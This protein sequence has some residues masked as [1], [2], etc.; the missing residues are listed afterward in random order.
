MILLI[1][2]DRPVRR[3]RAVEH[4]HG[5]DGEPVEGSIPPA[6]E[7][8]ARRVHEQALHH[9]EGIGEMLFSQDYA[10][11]YCGISMEEP[12]PRNFSFN[13]PHGACTVCTGLGLRMEV[14]ADAVVPD[15]SLSIMGGAL[16]GWTK[17][18]SQRWLMD[19]VEA[20]AR[21]LARLAPR[22]VGGH[23]RLSV[24]HAGGGAVPRFRRL[25]RPAR[26][27]LRAHPT[28]RSDAE[29]GSAPAAARSPEPAP[30]GH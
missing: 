10:C 12:A 11:V 3:E 29:H 15:P 1:P 13:S 16:S 24:Y 23:H 26:P 20:V 19:V 14:D 5:M 17:G 21:R 28:A 8:E 7:D 4:A 2:A 9:N 25:A 27:H 22:G 30:G 6:D 18:P